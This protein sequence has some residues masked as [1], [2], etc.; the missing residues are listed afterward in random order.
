MRSPPSAL[1]ADALGSRGSAARRETL[2]SHALPRLARSAGMTRPRRQFGPPACGGLSHDDSCG[3]RY[4][5]DTLDG[6]R[7]DS[8]F[9]LFCPSAQVRGRLALESRR[10]PCRHSNLFVTT[11]GPTG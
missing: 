6:L 7:R 10:S 5:D 9:W 8:R 4:S 11:S 1:E 3:L 2:H